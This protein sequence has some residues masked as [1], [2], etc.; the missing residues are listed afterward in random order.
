M[1]VSKMDSLMVDEVVS[2]ASKEISQQ[3]FNE[4]LALHQL[5]FNNE[6]NTKVKDML[7]NKILPKT[8]NG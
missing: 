7:P 2:L 8:G 6:L 5:K 4:K 1:V 3:T